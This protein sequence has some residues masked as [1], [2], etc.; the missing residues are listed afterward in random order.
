M[1][2][3]AGISEYDLEPAGAYKSSAELIC[4]A[5]LASALLAYANCRPE[6]ADLFK[7]LGSQL[8]NGIRHF[9]DEDAEVFQ[10]TFPP[11]GEEWERGVFDTWY[12]FH[13]LFHVL[14][15]ADGTDDNNLRT[16]AR[17]AT[18]RA[19]RFVRACDYHIPL[20]AKLTR[21][22]KRQDRDDGGIIGFALN[23][24]VLGM[25]AKVLVAAA[26][27]FP[28]RA[29]AWRDEATCALRRLRRWPLNQIFHQTVQLSWAAWA[30]HELGYPEWRDDFTRALLLTC[31][32]QG[33]LA[34][35]FC[36]CAGLR[37]PAFR[38][39]VEAVQPWSHWL[40]D[41]PPDLP[42]AQIIE[43]VF[44]QAGKFICT[45]GTNAGLPQEGLPT[46]EQPWRISRDIAAEFTTKRASPLD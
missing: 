16:A 20:F 34:G 25:Y 46:N 7:R 45:A 40:R 5:G 22:S 4:Q 12:L 6:D 23:P 35:L 24:S 42:L 32:R 2:Q 13:N 29:E 37:Y 8:S 11:K 28:D 1:H 14:S 18:E 19:I 43:L 3:L 27:I 26:A 38:E 10:N 30:A 15:A 44:A 21:N 36:G 33:D 9:Y 17:V 41:S 31:Y 39:T